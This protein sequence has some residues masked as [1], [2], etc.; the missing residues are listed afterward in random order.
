VV[1]SKL[2]KPQ[3]IPTCPKGDSPF[4]KHFCCDVYIACEPVPCNMCPDAD[5]LWTLIKGIA[6]FFDELCLILRICPAQSLIPTRKTTKSAD[7]QIMP[8]RIFQP[9]F[10][11]FV[12]FLPFSFSIFPTRFSKFTQRQFL[13]R[14]RFRMFERQVI[15]EAFPR[16]LLFIV[17]FIENKMFS[18]LHRERVAFFKGNGLPR[19]LFRES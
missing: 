11:H 15:P 17:C 8:P 13:V 2:N 3:S 10:K 4:Y 18:Q 9:L 5:G 14:N 7:D 16:R 1:Y 12:K 19:W 6:A